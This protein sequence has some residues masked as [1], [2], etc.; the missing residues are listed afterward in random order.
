MQIAVFNLKIAFKTRKTL[1]IVIPLKKGIQYL[2][3]PALNQVEWVE[4]FYPWHKLLRIH[5][6]D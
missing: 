3:P 4:D 1:L 2:S 5:R 6:N